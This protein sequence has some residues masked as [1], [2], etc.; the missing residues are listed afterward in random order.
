MNLK[1]L[2]WTLGLKPKVKTFGTDRLRFTLP[3]DGEIEFE[4]WHHP[5]DYFQPFDQP[6][7]DQ[8]RRY[9]R[10]GDT[11]IDIGAH[12][13]DFTLPMALAAGPRGV[14][15]AWEPNPCVFD[16]LKKNAALNRGKTHIIPVQA[17]AAETDGDMTFHYSD[18]GLCN[19][20]AM[21]DV[22][23][24]RHGHA[25]QLT[26]RGRRLNDWITRYYPERLA[27]ISFIKIDTEGYEPEVLQSINAILRRQRP[28]LH[29]EFHRHLNPERRDILW[30]LLDGLGYDVFKTGDGY[31]L[32]AQEQV[33]RKDIARWEHFDVLAL[34]K[35]IETAAA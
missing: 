24:W 19:G 35:R 5:K 17:A 16:V 4:K 33:L 25:F 29:V 22:S 31:G 8:L 30:S 18:P 9:I 1:S 34:P 3:K 20:G 13:G 2:L 6:L 23:R 7:V 26:V 15:F 11:V 12:T 32:A 14:V 10:P 27:R 28:Y 21:K